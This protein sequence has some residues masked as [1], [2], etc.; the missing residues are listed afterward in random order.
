KMPLNFLYAGIIALILPG[1]RM[2]HCRR[3]PLDTALS[4]YSLLFSRHQEYSYD[5]M[6]LG[7]YYRLYQRLMD[8]W[9]N[10]LGPEQFL[11]ID[12]E[13]MVEDSEGQ[14]ARILAFCDLPWDPACLRFYETKR[15]VTSA[16]FDQVRSPIHRKSIGRAQTFRA[17]LGPLIAALEN[18]ETDR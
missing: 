1:A 7:H 12:Y 4:C 18:V 6:E 10:L 5:Q 2:I 16:S 15:M 8:H 11:E 9:R 3:D 14:V 17:W 13:A